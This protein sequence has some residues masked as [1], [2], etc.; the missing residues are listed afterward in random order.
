M[1]YY[2]VPK[3]NLIV[4]LLWFLLYNYNYNFFYNPQTV[5]TQNK[6]YLDIEGHFM[7]TKKW[8]LKKWDQ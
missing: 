1:C 4:I 2:M 8:L 5:Q 7:L 6:K 3:Y